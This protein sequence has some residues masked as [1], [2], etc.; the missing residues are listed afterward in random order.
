[1]LDQAA[2]F[3]DALD[4]HGPGHVAHAALDLLAAPLDFAVKVANAN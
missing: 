4:D 1:M 3:L 2:L